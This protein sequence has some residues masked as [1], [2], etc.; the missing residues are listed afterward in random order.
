MQD[1]ARK[2]R[3]WRQDPVMFVRDNFNAEPDMWQVRALEA[4][5]STDPS[6]MRISLQAC[7]G[8]GKSAVISWCVWNFL[9]C[10]GEPGDH[11]K[12]AAVSITEINLKDN[13]WTELS[14]WQQRSK[15]L[16]ANFT[17]TRTRISANDH[18]ATWFFSARSFPKSA[19]PE[20]QGKTL[21][22][23]HS[24]YVMFA[25]DESGAIPI[26][27]AKA[28]EQAM[29]GD[30]FS[31]IIQAGNPISLDGM[32]YSA[33]LSDDWYVIRITGDPEDKERS[34]RID[35]DWAKSQ[36]Q[37]YG[38]DDPWVASYILGEFPSSSI[39]TLLSDA[40]VRAALGKHL[41]PDAYEHAQKRLG[42]DVA[43]FG[44]DSTVIF[45][46][47]GLAARRFVTMK[48]AR[49]HE[50]AARVMLAKQ[51]WGS[52]VEFVDGTGGF[53][54][55][56]IDS[57]IQ[58][59]ETPHEIHFSAKATDDRYYNKRAEMWFEMADWIKRGGA[60]PNDV[61]LKKEL[62]APTYSFK[63]GKF[64]LESKEQ[65]KKRLGFSPDRADALALTFAI[66]E[67]EGRS[68]YSGLN[69]NRNKMEHDYDPLGENKVKYEYDPMK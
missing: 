12:G 15:Y 57:M 40:D 48:Q 31:K 43:R 56:V 50:I 66:P 34:P 3:E 52:E 68:K 63:N 8:P 26:P 10:Y 24:K 7:A 27:V 13:L 22:G 59:G 37:K 20:E 19:D 49:S 42:I 44:Y 47:Q 39:N 28:A 58:A 18:P 65:I 45:P 6:K 36:I 4:F 30:G 5:K 46:R 60:I 11:P 23:V 69:K 1:A 64:I 53:G 14:K 62:C 16:T 67:V 2:I 32:L 33:S 41:L 21:S 25:I 29:G 38:R 35:M 51:R 55:G 9:S 54:S 17:W 61:Q